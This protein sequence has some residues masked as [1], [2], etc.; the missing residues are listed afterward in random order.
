M[1]YFCWHTPWSVDWTFNVA[2][3]NFQKDQPLFQTLIFSHGNTIHPAL[4]HIAEQAQSIGS[5]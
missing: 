1:I 4:K 2:A 3:Q 5:L